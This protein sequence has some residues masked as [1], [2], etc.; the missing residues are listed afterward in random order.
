[1]SPD[2]QALFWKRCVSEKKRKLSEEA[3]ITGDEMKVFID[4]WEQPSFIFRCFPLRFLAM[5]LVANIRATATSSKSLDSGWGLAGI[6]VFMA[7]AMLIL[8]R[9]T[10]LPGDEA[11]F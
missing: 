2:C 6:L 10:R 1:M 7:T 8:P 3:G 9:D 11:L 5:M 4:L